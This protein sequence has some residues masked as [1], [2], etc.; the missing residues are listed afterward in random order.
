MTD[1]YNKCKGEWNVCLTG[2]VFGI[3]IMLIFIMLW[4]M[5][6]AEYFVDPNA[7]DPITQSLLQNHYRSDPVVT[8]A[9]TECLTS[10]PR[11]TTNLWK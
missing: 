7:L 2:I 1:L 4:R 3:I 10:N 8:V 11:L 5:V 6:G 9:G